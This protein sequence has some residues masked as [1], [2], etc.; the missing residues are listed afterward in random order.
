MR[1]VVVLRIYL[2]TGKMIHSMG[3]LWN[4]TWSKVALIYRHLSLASI[5]LILI[6]IIAYY[7]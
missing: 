5:L 2:D 1:L 4:R 7:I 6:S 3:L